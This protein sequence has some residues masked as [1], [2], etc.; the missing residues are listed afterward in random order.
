M[1]NSVKTFLLL[2]CGQHLLSQGLVLVVFLHGSFIMVH[3]PLLQLLP[4]SID[5]QAQ[6]RQLCLQLT[7]PDS[8]T[9]LSQAYL[10]IGNC[11][12]WSLDA[13]LATARLAGIYI[14]IY[15]G[16][17]ATACAPGMQK[18]KAEVTDWTSACKHRWLREVAAIRHAIKSTAAQDK[19]CQNLL[20][21]P[22]WQKCQPAL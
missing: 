8:H 22:T 12:Q 1:P 19:L 4:A 14:Y 10:M 21:C 16:L 13:Q 9:S 18:W 3:Q 20:A 15:R 7:S 11:A 5:R 6:P 17:S 2:S